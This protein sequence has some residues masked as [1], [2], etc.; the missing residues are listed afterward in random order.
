MD[1]AAGGGRT[2]KHS[3]DAAVVRDGRLFAYGWA[4]DP[5]RPLRDVA[6]R[7]TYADGTLAHLPVT[8]GKERPDVAAA[9]PD[10]PLARWSGWMAYAGWDRPVRSIELSGTIEGG[11]AFALPVQG[12]PGS[13]PLAQRVPRLASALRRVLE[14]AQRQV[15]AGQGLVHV[16]HAALQAAGLLRLCVVIDHAMGGGANQYRERWVRERLST[17]PLLAVLGFEVHRMAWWLELHLATGQILRL[18]CG[19]DLPHELVKADLVGEVFANDAVSFPHPERVADWLHACADSGAEVTLAVHDYLAVCPSPF[20]LNDATRFCGVPDLGECRRCLEANPNTF[21]VVQPGPDIVA[22]RH[23]WGGALARATQ[24]LCFSESSRR[25]ILRAYPTLDPACI[26]VQPH[27]VPPFVRGADV[28]LDGPLHVGVVGAIGQHKGADVVHALAAESL[29][30]AVG[31]RITVFGTLEGTAD[32]RVVT[33]TGPY[34]R[35]DLPI[36]IEGAGANVFLLPSICPETFS[37][38]TH[39]LIGLG[40]PLACF[41]LGAPADRVRDYPD[42]RVLPLAG[43]S[44]LLDDLTQFHHDLQAIRPREGT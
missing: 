28:R 7:V 38:V 16:L 32:G 18:P 27:A 2:V 23:A 30:R 5:T 29:R 13:V 24:V 31:L 15:S 34:R 1:S 11:G 36:L 26:V 40:L 37:Y 19:D 39:E 42:G 12:E 43:A 10:E 22:W 41:D 8:A 25:L 21:P 4:Y 17:L 14:V 6:L 9:F 33:V 44:K 35:E 20:L 3:L